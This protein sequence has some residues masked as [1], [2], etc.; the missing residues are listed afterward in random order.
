MRYVSVNNLMIKQNRTQI[1]TIHKLIKLLY[2]WTYEH[3][4]HMRNAT[5]QQTNMY[6]DLNYTTRYEK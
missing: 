3:N 6:T 1:H 4:L 2:R 5:K